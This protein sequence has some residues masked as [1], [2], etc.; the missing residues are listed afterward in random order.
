MFPLSNLVRARSKG[1]SLKTNNRKFGKESLNKNNFL[2]KPTG[3]SHNFEETWLERN[4]DH[5]ISCP[6]QPGGLRISEKVCLK[7]YILGSRRKWAKFG[8][9]AE[10]ETGMGLSRCKVCPIGE[11]LKAKYEREEART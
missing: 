4:R 6:F 2:E 10:L 3:I 9:W 1:E 5:L 8:N 7:R 11:R